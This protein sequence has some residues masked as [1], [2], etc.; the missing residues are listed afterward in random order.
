MSKT[1]E[2]FIVAFSLTG[3]PEVENFVGRDK[4]LVEIKEAFQGNG[5]HRK[6]VILQGLGGIGK[7]Q[8]AVA[9]AKQ[10]RDQFSAVFWLNGQTEDTLK[11]SFIKIAKRLHNSHPSSTLLKR[12]AESKEPDQIIETVKQWLSAKGN[13]QWML[14]FDNIDNPKISGIIQEPRAYDIK[15]YFPEAHQGFILITTRSSQLK[16]GKV[17]PVRKLQNIGESIA[18]VSHMSERQISDQGW[19]HDHRDYPSRFYS[20]T[21]RSLCCGAGKNT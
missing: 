7:T 11:Q 1:N 10:Q 14:V 20:F 17:M 5:S 13:I 4:E 6:T 18:I 21:V 3:V 12:A 8:L 16:I 9:F 2:D 19:C 15:S